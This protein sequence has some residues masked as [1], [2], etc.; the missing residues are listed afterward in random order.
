MLR[1]FLKSKTPQSSL[2]L[3]VLLISIFGFIP[4]II[5]QCVTQ[6]ITALQDKVDVFQ[7]EWMAIGGLIAVVVGLIPTQKKLSEGDKKEEQ[8]K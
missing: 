6:I 4:V 7:P 8:E 5:T 2:R 1:E 3:I